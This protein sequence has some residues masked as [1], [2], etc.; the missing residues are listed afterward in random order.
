M[1]NALIIKSGGGGLTVKSGGTVTIKD[2]GQPPYVIDGLEQ[3]HWDVASAVVTGGLVDSI[4][5][6]SNVQALTLLTLP[7]QNPLKSAY[8]ASGWQLNGKTL[9]TCFI[10]RGVDVSNF[11]GYQANAW[12]TRWPAT[13]GP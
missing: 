4:P 1:A 9:P 10:E 2:S 11:R 6:S 8:N 7:G 3:S 13:P 12:A 5:D